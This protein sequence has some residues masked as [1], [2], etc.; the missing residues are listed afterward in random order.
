MS[1]VDDCYDTGMNNDSA[2]YYNFDGLDKYCYNDCPEGYYGDPQ[3][4][5]CVT[6]CPVTT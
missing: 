1:C 4:H 2:N 6:Q 5:Y 3:S